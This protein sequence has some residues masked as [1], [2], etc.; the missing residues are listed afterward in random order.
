MHHAIGENLPLAIGIAISPIPIIASILML[1]SPRARRTSLAFGFGW[2]VGV[3]LSVVAFTLLAGVLPERHADGSRPGFAV[4]QV[5]LG[6]ALLVL[7]A[8]R[9]RSRP[10][11]DEDAKLPAWMAA[12]DAIG[13]PK[14]LTLGFLLAAI[15]VKNLMLSLSAGATFGH[16]DLGT[17]ATAGTIAIF[18]VIAVST[19]AIP[20]IAFQ[21]APQ[22]IGARLGPVRS[23]LVAHNAAIMS[24]LLL[25]LGAHVLG[26][27]IAGF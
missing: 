12:I 10:Q 18:V 4:L 1:L 24:V 5:V 26:K 20:V 15:N 9:W 19:V 23:W 2:L 6:V 14:A 3:V 11:P 22:R 17:R 8:R 21:L 13:T 7:C 25:V 27:G 16:A